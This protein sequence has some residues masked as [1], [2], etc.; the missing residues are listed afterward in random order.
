MDKNSTANLIAP[1]LSFEDAVREL[2]LIVSQMENNQLPLQ[3][4]LTAF[5]RGSSLLQ[6]CQ[7]TLADVAQ[8][9]RILNEDGTLNSFQDSGE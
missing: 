6:H 3:D 4:A 1:D 5:K 7:K 2:E 8:Q 9:I